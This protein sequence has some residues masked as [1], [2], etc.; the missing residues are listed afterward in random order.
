MSYRAPAIAVTLLAVGLALFLYGRITDTHP[1][2]RA[3]VV[4]G[5]SGAVAVVVT[6]QRRAAERAAQISADQLA[7]ADRAGY[8]RGVDHATRGLFDSPTAPTGHPHT[9]PTLATIHH[10]HTNPIRKAQ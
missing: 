1:I 8:W 6:Q 9:A 5:F 7:D 3:G 2:G 4:S 10:L